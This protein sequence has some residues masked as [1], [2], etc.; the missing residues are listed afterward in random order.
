[1]SGLS[2]AGFNEFQIKYV[3]GKTIPLSDMVYLQSLESEISEKYPKIYNDY[4]SLKPSVDEELR[5]TV[6]MYKQHDEMMR[7]FE[8]KIPVNQEQLEGLKNQLVKMN[9]ALIFLSKEYLNLATNHPNTS[10][11]SV[12][13]IFKEI[14]KKLGKEW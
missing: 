9:D 13:A 2:R 3:M 14:L 12:E 1:M 11:E 6:E 10:K 4:L 7:Q 5:K 8:G